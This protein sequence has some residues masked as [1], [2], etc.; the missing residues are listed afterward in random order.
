MYLDHDLLL[1]LQPSKI[2]RFVFNVG[3]MTF[4]WVCPH[5]KRTPVH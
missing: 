3:H 4:D 5:S 2:A 1:F